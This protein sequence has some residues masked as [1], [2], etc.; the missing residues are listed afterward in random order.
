MDHEKLAQLDVDLERSGRWVQATVVRAAGVGYVL[1]TGERRIAARIRGGSQQA[2]VFLIEN[3]PQLLAWF[4]LDAADQ[5]P[6]EP[7]RLDEVVLLSVKIKKYLDIRRPDRMDETLAEHFGVSL[8]DL[9][10]AR[11]IVT[12]AESFPDGSDVRKYGYEQLR[13]VGEGIY[14]PTTGFDRVRQFKTRGLVAANAP[15]PNRQRQIMAQVTTTLAGVTDA[16]QALGPLSDILESGER[17]AWDA[18]L[19]ATRRQLEKT[20]RDIRRRE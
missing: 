11:Q 17:S 8:D 16:L 19:S 15:T 7:M 10:S 12:L 20:L 9:R 3:W 13:L 1:L 6:K 14:R 5:H 2:T 18:Q 4:C